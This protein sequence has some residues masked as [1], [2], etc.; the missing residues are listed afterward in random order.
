MAR[1]APETPLT[2]DEMAPAAPVA[3]PAADPAGS[4]ATPAPAATGIAVAVDR[5]GRERP[6]SGG[7]FVRVNGKLQR[8]EA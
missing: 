5:D 1:K 2:T 3:E 6:L 4:A 7:S 8:R